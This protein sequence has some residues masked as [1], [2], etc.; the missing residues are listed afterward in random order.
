MGK[1]TPGLSVE[2]RANR[3]SRMLRQVACPVRGSAVGKPT[4]RKA[5]QAPHLDSISVTKHWCTNWPHTH[6]CNE[7]SKGGSKR[8]F[9]ME[10]S[11]SPPRL[12]PHKV[13][14]CRRYLPTWPCMV[15]KLTF[16]LPSR[17]RSVSTA[18][19]TKVGSPC[20]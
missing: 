15:L 10:W 1:L 14:H 20:W 3:E 6:L 17:T 4:R 9:G 16:G 7:S 8:E 2:A 18:N 19:V 12:E 11:S 13:A 5:G